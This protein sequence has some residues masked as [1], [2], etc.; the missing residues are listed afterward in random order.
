MTVT[1]SLVLL[2]GFGLALALK[3]K[4]VGAGAATLAA[5]FGFYLADT[6]AAPSINEFTTAIATALN[7]IGN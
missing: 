4:S 6:D 1:V 5:L 7:D 2:L 3:F